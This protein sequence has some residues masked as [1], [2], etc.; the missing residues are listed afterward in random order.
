MSQAE[1]DS[2]RRHLVFETERLCVFVA[3]E[4]DVELFYALWTDPRVMRNVGFPQGLP[5]AREMILDQLKGQAGRVFDPR[6]LAQLH[7]SG[8]PIGECKLGWPNDMGISSTDVKLLPTYWGNKYGVEIKQ[9]LVDYLFTHTDCS[10]VEATPNVENKAS[11]KMQEAVGGVC[12]GEATFQVP[13]S[14]RG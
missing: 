4:G 6:L 14:R 7:E 1:Y 9:A 5:I 3:T 8:D 13:E 11:I 10:A 2:G 12:V